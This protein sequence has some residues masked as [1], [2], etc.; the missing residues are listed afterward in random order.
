MGV[1]VIQRGTQQGGEAPEMKAAK[2]PQFG[3]EEQ[4]APSMDPFEAN[5]A[6]H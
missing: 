1:T 6:L 4:W 3:E 5:T 2:S